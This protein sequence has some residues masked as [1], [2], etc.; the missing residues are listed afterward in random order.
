MAVSSTL[1][2]VCSDEIVPVYRRGNEQRPCPAGIAARRRVASV[3]DQI[4]TWHG[5]R[6]ARSWKSTTCGAADLVDEPLE[7]AAVQ[8]AD[9]VGVG[10]RRARRTGSARRRPWSHRR[11]VHRGRVEAQLV[12]HRRRPR[13]THGRHRTGALRWARRRPCVAAGVR[14]GLAV[15]A[16][17][18]TASSQQ[19]AGQHGEHR[20]LQA[21]RGRVGR[22]ASTASAGGRPRRGCRDGPRAGRRRASAPGG[23]ARCWGAVRATRRRPRWTGA[24]ANGPAPGR[25][26]SACC[27]PA[28]SAGRGGRSGC[29]TPTMVAPDRDNTATTGKIT[30]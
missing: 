11:L 30:P 15:D 13:R 12:Q 16:R 25:S 18:R 14:G 2:H 9:Q 20:R 24:G 27:R 21:E 22:Q 3:A 19:H 28:S 10:L 8:R 17:R 26:R 1:A 7:Q 29:D 6:C 5:A 23:A 4:R